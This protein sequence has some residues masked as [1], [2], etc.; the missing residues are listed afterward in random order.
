MD[1]IRDSQNSSLSKANAQGM[2]NNTDGNVVQNLANASGSQN[3]ADNSSRSIATQ[4]ISDVPNTLSVSNTPNTPSGSAKPK[5]VKPKKRLLVICGII[6]GIAVLAGVCVVLIMLLLKPEAGPGQPTPEEEQKRSEDNRLVYQEVY[7]KATEN[8]KESANQVFEE[9]IV[10]SEGSE[11]SNV[12]RVAQ[13]RYSMEQGDYDKVIEI[14]KQVGDKGN[15]DSNGE[16]NACEDA[17]LDLYSRAVCHNFMELAYRDMDEHSLADQHAK[18]NRELMTEYME[19][20]YGNT[21]PYGQ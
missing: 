9:E 11:R 19:Q 2:T 20:K 7:D 6:L 5:I 16:I 12:A 4:V 15:G 18:R 3:N 1:G 14:G 10:S 8:D 17:N 13:M 21:G